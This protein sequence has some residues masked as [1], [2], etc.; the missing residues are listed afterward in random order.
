MI[1]TQSAGNRSIRPPGVRPRVPSRPQ[2]LKESPNGIELTAVTVC[3]ALQFR[4]GPPYVPNSRPAFAL[5]TDGRAGAD[6]WGSNDNTVKTH[7][8]GHSFVGLMSGPF[9]PSVDFCAE[10]E[11]SMT[12]VD[13]PKNKAEALKR[14]REFSVYYKESPLYD[15]TNFDVIVSGFPGGKP[16]LFCIHGESQDI[17]VESRIGVDAVG[18]G[19]FYAKAILNLRSYDFLNAD[20]PTATYSAYE[21]KRF[22]ETESNVGPRTW[23]KIH[24]LDDSGDCVLMD[25]GPNGVT[26]LEEWLGEYFIRSIAPLKGVEFK[27]FVGAPPDLQ[28]PT[29]DR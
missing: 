16:A 22:S 18:S 3:I 8:L 17:T 21:A 6:E 11:S 1:V 13:P 10:L 4:L 7:S 2:P 23:L 28:F 29:R 20:F 9:A 12:A 14:I 19:A 15:G 25:I 5:C 27:K 26:Q 24:V